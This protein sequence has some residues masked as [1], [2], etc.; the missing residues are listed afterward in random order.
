MYA[1]SEIGPSA[2]GKARAGV[3]LSG[4]AVLFL[5]FDSI[6][7][8]LKVAPVVA[9]TIHLGLCFA[10]IHRTVRHVVQDLARR[11]DMLPTLRWRRGRPSPLCEPIHR[12]IAQGCSVHAPG[13][14]ERAWGLSKSV[15]SP[16]ARSGGGVRRPPAAR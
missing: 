10:K 9:G 13:R 8:L 15:T 11:V 1:S 3:V 16:G 6:G 4:I 12:R 5:L 2:T 14:S 7:K